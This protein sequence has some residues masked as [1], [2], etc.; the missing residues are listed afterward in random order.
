[1]TCIRAEDLCNYVQQCVDKTD[2]GPQCGMSLFSQFVC[3]FYFIFCFV[4]FIS[5]RIKFLTTSTSP[6]P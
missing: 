6:L 1:M 5:F 4:S 3:L 2:E